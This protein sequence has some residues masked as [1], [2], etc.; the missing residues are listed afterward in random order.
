M[1]W[2]QILT[3]SSALV[4]MLLTWHLERRY[5]RKLEHH[6]KQILRTRYTHPEELSEALTDA[7]M[8]F[9]DLAPAGML[10]VTNN[11]GEFVLRKDATVGLEPPCDVPP[12]GWYC[13]R[14][15]GHTGPCAAMPRLQHRNPGKGYMPPPPMPKPVASEDGSF[16]LGRHRVTPPE[17]PPKPAPDMDNKTIESCKL[18]FPIGASNFGGFP[19]EKITKPSLDLTSNHIALPAQTVDAIRREVEHALARMKAQGGNWS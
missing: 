18:R 10:G 19:G 7:E 13:T 9:Y 11:E 12:A 3:I 5:S 16:M 15:R 14:K 17:P 8:E 4:C 6:L 1:N 2:W